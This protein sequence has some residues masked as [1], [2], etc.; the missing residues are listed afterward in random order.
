MKF[1][2]VIILAV[3]V[4]TATSKA[5]GPPLTESGTFTAAVYCTPS[6]TITVPP[7]GPPY[8]VNIGNFFPDGI[9]HDVLLYNKKI[10]WVLRGPR[11]TLMGADIP[12]QINVTGHYIDHSVTISTHWTI[13][14]GN[15]NI[16]PPGVYG[17]EP[18]VDDLT[19][20]TDP[21]APAGC[22]GLTIFEIYA[23]TIYVPIG[24][25]PGQRRFDIS[26][27]VNVSI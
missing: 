18:D 8:E 12:Y 26:M 20:G 7:V 13:T 19:L 6:L 9:L 5:I 17:G 10:Q 15:Y 22:D 14:G 1:V 27:T 3:V 4:L 21:M 25:T 16:D 11:Q 24:A 2:L 23:V